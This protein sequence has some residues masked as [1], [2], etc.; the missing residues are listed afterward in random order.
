MNVHYSEPNSLTCICVIFRSCTV[1]FNFC[2]AFGN[3]TF[4]ATFH[5]W[6]ESE[7]F[8]TLYKYLIR[9]QV[10]E[11]FTK[12]SFLLCGFTISDTV[13]ILHIPILSGCE[14]DCLQGLWKCSPWRATVSCLR[15][16]SSV[17]QISMSFPVGSKLAGTR[18]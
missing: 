13:S 18:S 6:A 8:I 11:H 7:M 10:L 1:P 2:A 4:P 16:V 5:K 14:L 15:M 3:T 17:K 12:L 9:D